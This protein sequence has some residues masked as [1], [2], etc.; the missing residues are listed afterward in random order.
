[1]KTKTDP[2]LISPELTVNLHGIKFPLE[3]LYRG[4]LA[5]GQPGSGKTRCI[6]MPLIQSI[7]ATTGN[8]P[9]QKAAMIIADPKGELAPF[10]EEA[11]EAVGRSDDLVVLKPSSAY[12]NPL[13][14]PFWVSNERTEK[15]VAMS[16]NINRNIGSNFRGEDAFW[17]NAQRALLSAVVE[18][19]GLSGEE[20][21]FA[22]LNKTFRQIN[23]LQGSEADAWIKKMEIP[24]GPAQRIRDFVRLPSE[25]T[26]PCVATSVANALYFWGNE[27]LASLVTPKLTLPAIDPIDIIHRGKVLVISCSSAAYGASITPLLLALKEHAFAALLSRNEIEVQ[28]HQDDWQSIN[29]TRPVFVIAD[30][31]QSYVSPNSTVGELTALDRLRGFNA[32]YIAA[33]QNLSSLHSV[34]GDVMHGT[35]LISLFA[36]QVYLSNICPITTAQAQQICGAKTKRE[37]RAM[38]DEPLA[39]PLL[40]RKNYR[41]CPARSNGGRAHYEPRI[42]SSTLAEMKTGEFWIRRADGRVFKRKAPFV[43]SAHQ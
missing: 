16:A 8:D 42:T 40:L 18:V 29:S 4:L 39:P 17:A 5:V 28:D 35:R 34:L 20:L 37:Q 14:S 25:T 3:Y 21:T 13:S 32:G 9:E 31:F 11:L 23:R 30:E 2:Y 6:L 15:I 38:L 19:A 1:M 24:S 12:Y 10:M 36:N 27:P 22:G 43:S 7:L 33:T 26:R 41:H